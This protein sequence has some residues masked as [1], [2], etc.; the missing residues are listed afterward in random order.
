MR[1]C[2]MIKFM[3]TKPIT[4]VETSVFTRRADKILGE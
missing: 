3:K 1:H 2:R 4:V